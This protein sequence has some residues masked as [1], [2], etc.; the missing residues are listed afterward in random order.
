MPVKEQS[1]LQDEAAVPEGGMTMRF[2]NR[3]EAG[4]QL[5][6]R[7]RAYAKEKDVI[8]LGIPRGGVPVAFEVSAELGAPLDIFVVRKLGVPWQ[9]ELAFGAIASGGVRVL[10]EEVVESAGISHLE[11]ERVAAREE[12]ELQR[13]EKIYRGG[14]PALALEGKTV[15]LVDDGIATGASTR[16]AITAL[17]QMNPG[18]IVLAA[19][20][21][22]GPTYRRLRSE[23]DDFVCVDTP[24]TFYAIGEFYEDFSQV[25]DEEVMELLQPVNKRRP[26]TQTATDCDVAKEVHS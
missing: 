4:R 13:R 22:P 11:I 7:L 15:I 8:V 19:P 10:D 5:A 20:V 18:R 21:A 16:A 2:L 24:E 1:H 26:H 14:R 17:R 6:K 3:V 12:L 9:P 23:V 25:S